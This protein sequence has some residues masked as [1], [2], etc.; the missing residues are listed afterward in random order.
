MPFGSYENAFWVSLFL[1]V[2]VETSVLFLVFRF[3]LRRS[4][5]FARKLFAGTFPSFATL[6]YLW[7]L[8][9]VYVRDRTLYLW[10]GETGV[11]LIETVLLM[12]VL[13]VK[14]REALL[15]SAAANAASYGLG[16][17]FWELV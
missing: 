6:P 4:V 11:V 13:P 2:A 9:P 12:G 16:R 7:F 3:G 14:W 8:L 5:P 10:S 1:T 17:I 15:L